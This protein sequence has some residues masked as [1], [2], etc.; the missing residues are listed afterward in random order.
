MHSCHRKH[1]CIILLV[2]D[3]EWQKTPSLACLPL[4]CVA[5]FVIA[6]AKVGGGAQNYRKHLIPLLY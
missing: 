1:A 2:L 6:H 3:D 5:I 4:T